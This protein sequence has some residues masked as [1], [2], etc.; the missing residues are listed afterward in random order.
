MP[1]NRSGF[2]VVNVGDLVFIIGGN[3]GQ[4]ILNTV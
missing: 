2:G 1:N 3:D 4:N